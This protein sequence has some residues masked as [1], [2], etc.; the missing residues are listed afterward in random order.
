MYYFKNSKI[1]VFHFCFY[2]YFA[3]AYGIT[4]HLF[5]GSKRAKPFQMCRTVVAL[6]PGRFSAVQAE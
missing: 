6:A 2:F 1:G 4:V 3:L 5:T